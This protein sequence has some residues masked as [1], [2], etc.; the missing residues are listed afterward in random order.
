M[1]VHVEFTPHA[2]E[3]L[4]QLDSGIANRIAAKIQWLSERYDRTQPESLTGH[5]AGLY[6]LRVGDWRVLYAIDPPERIMTVH[7]IAHRSKVYK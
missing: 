7:V 2:L 6:K 5:F 4:A 1:I 3:D